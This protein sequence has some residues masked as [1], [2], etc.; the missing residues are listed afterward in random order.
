MTR[1]A[2]TAPVAVVAAVV[3]DSGPLLA[4]FNHLTTGMGA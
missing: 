1:R 3:A 4:L 2:S